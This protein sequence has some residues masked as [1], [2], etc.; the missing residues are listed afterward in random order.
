MRQSK[1]H[2]WIHILLPALLAALRTLGDAPAR[3]LTAL[4]QRLGVSE[5]DAASVVG[6]VEENPAP[7]ATPDASLLPMTGRNDGLSAPKSLLNRPTVIPTVSPLT[8]PLLYC[9]INDFQRAFSVE[10]P[11]PGGENTMAGWA[12]HPVAW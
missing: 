11:W 3:S 7:V 9:H 2:Q 4:A 6:S 5:I 8:I 10:K 12:A 1:A